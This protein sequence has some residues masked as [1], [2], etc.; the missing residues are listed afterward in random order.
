MESS[1][2]YSET[3]EFWKEKRSGD[4]REID[5]EIESGTSGHSFLAGMMIGSG[6]KSPASEKMPLRTEELSLEN[7]RIREP[8]IFP[9]HPSA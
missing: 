8:T 4:G 7:Q 9:F 2:T 6:R 3:S 1:A 5:I